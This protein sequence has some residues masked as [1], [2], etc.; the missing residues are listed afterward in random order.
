MVLKINTFKHDTDIFM[1]SKFVW[2]TLWKNCIWI[3]LDQIPQIHGSNTNT[4]TGLFKKS[5]TNRGLRNY[6]YKCVFDPI[7]GRGQA[8]AIAKSSRVWLIQCCIAVSRQG[9]A[10]EDPVKV[11]QSLR[12]PDRT[13]FWWLWLSETG[14][15]Q[16][17]SFVMN[18]KMPL[19]PTFLNRQ[20]AIAC[21]MMDR[22]GCEGVVGIALLSEGG[23]LATEVQPVKKKL[24][25]CI[26]P[27][28]AKTQ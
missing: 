12:H 11:V 7:P 17:F 25:S 5:N 15:I 26:M 1:P 3:I 22:L 21:T 18:S 10:T 16:Q 14:S 6:K 8:I 4:N 20:L 24:L 13:A 28:E 2:S 9:S 23:T 19:E 27:I